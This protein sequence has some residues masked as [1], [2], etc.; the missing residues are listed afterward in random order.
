M[1]KSGMT[2]KE[3]VRTSIKLSIDKEEKDENGSSLMLL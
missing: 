1:I 3:T 2:R